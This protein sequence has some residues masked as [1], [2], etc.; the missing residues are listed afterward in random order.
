[1]TAG[2]HAGRR[3]PVRIVCDV[4]L[5]VG[6]VLGLVC[7][8][9]G[10]AAAVFDVRP[11][12]V[13]SGSMSPA[14]PTGSLILAVE[15]PA[16]QIT[17]GDVVSVVDRN[18]TRITHRVTDRHAVATE[19]AGPVA[20]T[21]QGDAN[22][23]PDAEPY[24][25]VTADRVFAHVPHLGYLVAWASGPVGMF[26]LGG[27]AVALILSLVRRTPQRGGTGSA[28]TP[29]IV[30]GAAALGIGGLWLH[31]SVRPAVTQAAFTD[32]PTVGVSFIAASVPAPVGAVGCTNGASFSNQIT[33]SWPAVAGQTS[34]YQYRVEIY[35]A[36]LLGGENTKLLHSY[37][38]TGTSQVVHHSELNRDFLW[39][40]TGNVV[41]YGTVD[42]T[43]WRSSDDLRRTIV[44]GLTGSGFR[45]S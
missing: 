39:S 9:G 38:L 27:V 26:V 1:M 24:V 40:G 42:G 28:L 22:E 17:E 6:A 16:D 5:W 35:Q 11:M 4:L 21:L 43:T 14:I 25:V 13:Q 8:I 19:G 31:P 3:D 37:V 41:V 15:V 29:V 36:A 23:V 33:L 32:A 10:V 34:R 12:V 20:L 7:M 44:V 45:C 30:A 18:G 2:A